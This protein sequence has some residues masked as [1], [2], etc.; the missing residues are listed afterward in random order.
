M[1]SDKDKNDKKSGLDVVIMR[2]SFYVDSYYR[3]LTAL[4]FLIFINVGLGILV[5]YKWSH[6]PL[7]QYFA[8]TADGRIIKIHALSDPTV[9]DDYVL[10]WTATA[11]RKAFSWDF[12]HYREQLQ[13]SSANFTP[14]AW[15]QF[16]SSLKNSD[17]LKTLLDLKM[18]S[19]L[20]ITS[21]PQIIAKQVVDGHYA[22]SIK[23][24][25]ILK[26]VSGNKRINQ[27]LTMN[28][29]VMRMPVSYYPQKIAIRWL[30]YKT[31]GLSAYK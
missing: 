9:P 10:Q 4:L 18:V 5:Y 7:P 28:V 27:P 1:L 17:D 2:N 25:V 6:P 21:A 24:P 8:A 12:V 19:S 26:F 14:V 30:D 16:V 29:L 20:D 23:V 3:V 15:R 11:L 22:W 31:V 13:E